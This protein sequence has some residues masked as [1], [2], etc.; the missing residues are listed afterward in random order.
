[1]IG[2]CRYCLSYIPFARELVSRM[3]TNFVGE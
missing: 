1:M 2:F 3:V